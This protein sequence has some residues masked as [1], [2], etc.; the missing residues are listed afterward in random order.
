MVISDELVKVVQKLDSPW[1][2]LHYD[3]GNSMMAWEELARAA[4]NMAPYTITTHFKDHIVIPSPDDPYG[5]GLRHPGR[6]GNIDLRNVLQDHPGR[7]GHHASQPR[8]VLSV[9]RA[10]QAYTGHRWCGQ[11]RRRQFQGR[12]AALRMTRG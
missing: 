5:R 10:V 7:L 8:N 12:S 2:G 3:F 11:C 1:I 4:Q 6:E 9:L